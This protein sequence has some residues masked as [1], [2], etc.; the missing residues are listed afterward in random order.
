VACATT[1]GFWEL[2]RTR[3]EDPDFPAMP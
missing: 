1:P 2:K 3:S